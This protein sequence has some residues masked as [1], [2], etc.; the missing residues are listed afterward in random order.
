MIAAVEVG[1]ALARPPRTDRL[2]RVVVEVACA[3]WRELPAAELEALALALAIA[4]ARPD[5][6]MP[7]SARIVDVLEV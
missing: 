7:V 4:S 5:V 2:C 1:V 3:S 6:V